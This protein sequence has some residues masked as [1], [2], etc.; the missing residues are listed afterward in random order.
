VV[1]FK[2]ALGLVIQ[3]V[4]R[5]KAQRVEG[6]R[7][8]LVLQKVQRRVESLE[9]HAVQANLALS[10]LRAL[11]LVKLARQ[12]E[13]PKDALVPLKQSAVKHHVVTQSQKRESLS[14]SIASSQVG[15]RLCSLLMRLLG[16]RGRERIERV[17][18]KQGQTSIRERPHGAL[19]SEIWIDSCRFEKLIDVTQDVLT[20]ESL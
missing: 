3:H 13:V 2:G 12:E 19:S 20:E 16:E 18:V 11:E 5:H 10:R 17:T 6:Q 14:H 1:N 15:W 9:D 4:A 7:E 8:L